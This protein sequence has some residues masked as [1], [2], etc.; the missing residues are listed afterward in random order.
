MQPWWAC[1]NKNCCVFKNIE[2]N[3]CTNSVVSLCVWCRSSIVSVMSWF[4]SI[5]TAWRSDSGFPPPPNPPC[6]PH[7]MKQDHWQ[8]HSTPPHPPLLPVFLSS[9]PDQKA[10]GRKRDKKKKMRSSLP[11][12]FFYPKHLNMLH[13]FLSWLFFRFRIFFSTFSSKL[14]AIPEPGLV[15]CG[16]FTSARRDSGLFLKKAALFY[17]CL[18]LSGWLDWRAEINITWRRSLHVQCSGDE[19]RASVPGLL[20]RSR[21]PCH[22]PKIA[23]KGQNTH[24]CTNAD[25]HTHTHTE[26]QPADSFPSTAYQDVDASST[27]RTHFSPPFSTS[28][29]RSL[30]LYMVPYVSRGDWQEGQ[31]AML[32]SCGFPILL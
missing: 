1:E 11:V 9:Y 6:W 19:S 18:F 26:I 15:R 31:A 13:P 4:W 32:P 8:A 25:I 28:L 10:E 21:A 7:C 27:Q 5:W 3:Y 23:A 24:A 14:W 22:A 20:K 16:W 2:V 12:L 30:L 17:T 29:R